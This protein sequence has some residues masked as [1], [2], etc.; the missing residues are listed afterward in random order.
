MHILFLN[1]TILCLELYLCTSYEENLKTEACKY[2]NNN[3]CGGG[4]ECLYLIM[5][6]Y[7]YEYVPPTLVYFRFI[8]TKE[9]KGPLKT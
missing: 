5:H 6:H 2:V 7:A 8:C 3:Q 9:T 1:Y 4:F